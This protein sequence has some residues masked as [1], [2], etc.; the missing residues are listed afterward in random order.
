ML[1]VP[2]HPIRSPLG[3]PVAAG[4]EGICRLPVLERP[5]RDRFCGIAV[6][7]AELRPGCADSRRLLVLRDA[8]IHAAEF[9]LP[10]SPLRLVAQPYGD[11]SPLEKCPMG[12]L[13]LWRSNPAETA[14]FAYAAGIARC[15][16]GDAAVRGAI[17][18]KTVGGSFLG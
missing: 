17:E 6:Q 11:K 12:E 4:A 10:C 18:G 15:G 5:N 7:T 3:H 13:C 16:R 8:I 2:S 1:G 9:A 14:G